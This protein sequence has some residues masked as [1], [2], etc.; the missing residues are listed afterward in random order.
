MM[1]L[2]WAGINGSRRRRKFER[3]VEHR[4]LG[5]YRHLLIRNICT[6]IRALVGNL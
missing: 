4:V 3:L 1:D 2:L 5:T 6:P